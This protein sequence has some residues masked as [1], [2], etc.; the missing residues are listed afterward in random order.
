MHRQRGAKDFPDQL[1]NPVCVH[2]LHFNPGRYCLLSESEKNDRRSHEHSG[3]SEHTTERAPAPKSVHTGCT[4]AHNTGPSPCIHPPM[5]L[6]ARACRRSACRIMMALLPSPSRSVCSLPGPLPALCLRSALAMYKV[7]SVI[8]AIAATMII[9]IG[10]TGHAWT[11]HPEIP[12]SPVSA[13]VSRSLRLEQCRKATLTVRVQRQ[14][15]PDCAC[16]CRRFGEP[17][18]GVAHDWHCGSMQSSHSKPSMTSRAPGRI[19]LPCFSASSASRSSSHLPGTNHARRSPSFSH[20][21]QQALFFRPIS[22]GTAVD[23]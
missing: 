18:Y 21:L 17:W 1:P 2:G 6:T 16:R 15:K 4:R 7:E 14:R 8:L 3:T 5:L 23:A 9:V 11:M 19:S 13:P 12:R 22:F 10:L 20:A